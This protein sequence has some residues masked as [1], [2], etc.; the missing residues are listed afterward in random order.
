MMQALLSKCKVLLG[1]RE[2][3]PGGAADV[4]KNVRLVA[5]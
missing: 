3:Q 5:Q 1:G 4:D 2:F